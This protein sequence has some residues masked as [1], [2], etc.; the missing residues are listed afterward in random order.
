MEKDEKKDV[1]KKENTPVP[2]SERVVLDAKGIGPI[3]S[4]TIS[5]KIDP[6]MV[7]I[8]KEFFDTKCISCHLADS[9][10]VGPAPKGILSRRSPEYIM[11]MMLNPEEMIKKDPLAKELLEEF[12]GVPM[13]DQ[14]LNEKEARAILEYFRTL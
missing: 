8:G 13:I 11:N 14:G 1:S 5:E 3:K 10:L 7:S 9:K 2:P 12:K 4:V 6:D